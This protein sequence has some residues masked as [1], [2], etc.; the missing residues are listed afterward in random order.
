MPE[1]DQLKRPVTW[2]AWMPNGPLSPAAPPCVSGKQKESLN[3]TLRHPGHLQEA[4]NL[5][6]KPG[7]HLED[8]RIAGLFPSGQLCIQSSDIQMMVIHNK[9][10]ERRIK[11]QCCHFC[12]IPNPEQG[13]DQR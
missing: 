13:Q 2:A 8:I 9:K 4:R 12:M 5:L 1:C 3:S 11:Q 6:H 10:A 7:I